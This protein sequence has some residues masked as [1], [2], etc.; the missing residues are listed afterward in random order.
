[1]RITLEHVTK[2]VVIASC[3]FVAGTVAYRQFG[4]RHEAKLYARGS[5]IR[6]TGALG[7]ANYGR[8]L[9]LAASS[10]CP[11]CV[12]SVPFYRKLSVAAKRGGTRV[13]AVSLEMPDT[14]RA[15][16]EGNGVHIDAVV[17]VAGSGVEV[18]LTPMLILV[19]KDGSVIDSWAGEL[20][21]GQQ[22]QVLDAAE[23]R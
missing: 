19:H 5:H 17:P 1:M 20:S 14:N 6:D 3:L 21:A 22:S 23:Q 10:A 12:A 15:F 9:L 13:V 18:P 11:H 4:T 8:T 7:L 2:A 16:L